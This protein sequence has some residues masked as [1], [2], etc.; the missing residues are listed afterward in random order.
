MRVPA[1]LRT[2]SLTSF[3]K[4]HSLAFHTSVYLSAPGSNI[5]NPL[6]ISQFLF[7]QPSKVSASLSELLLKVA[8]MSQAPFTRFISS[9][10]SA[11]S[12]QSHHLRVYEI[13]YL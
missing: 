12:Y 6:Q 7:R 2:G 5:E 9:L 4:S 11:K 10:L 8:A 3:A 13:P 1:E